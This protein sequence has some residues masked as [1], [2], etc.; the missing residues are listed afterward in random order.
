[1]FI[2]E[3]FPCPIHAMS[4]R[5]WC[6]GSR[7]ASP[8]TR[9]LRRCRPRMSLAVR[10]GRPVSRRHWQCPAVLPASWPW[11]RGQHTGDSGRRRPQADGTERQARV[12]PAGRARYPVKLDGPRPQCTVMVA[13]KEAPASI[14]T[15]LAAQSN[16]RPLPLHEQTAT[17]RQSICMRHNY[18]AVGTGQ[19]LVVTAR[20]IITQRLVA[21]GFAPASDGLSVVVPIG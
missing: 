4:L 8:P 9:W 1:M 2:R 18:Q 20:A 11:F 17:G 7:D 12:P 16:L 6:C 13:G 10:H 14:E 5:L 3:E 21:S 19:V 15:I